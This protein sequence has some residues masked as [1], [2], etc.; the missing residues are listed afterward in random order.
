MPS[1]NIFGLVALEAAY[2][3]GDEW[4]EQFLD[5]MQDNLDFLIRYFDNNISKIKVIK[6]EGTYLVWLDCRGL[7]MEAEDLAVFMNKKAKVGLDHGYAFGPGGRGFERI[8]I[9]CPRPLLEQ[10][11]KRIEKA[12][13]DL[14]M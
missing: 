7:N 4:L 6:P 1:A 3:H 12:V 9:A 5:H 14:G 2:N 10:A 11:L 8:N 13:N